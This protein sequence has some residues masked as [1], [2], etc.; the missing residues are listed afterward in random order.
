[1]DENF[2][3]NIKKRGTVG[4]GIKINS[5]SSSQ[6]KLGGYLNASIRITGQDVLF[7]SY[8]K[9]FLPGYNSGLI[10]NDIA[11]IQFTKNFSFK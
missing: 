10:R 7:L 6:A 5:L 1:M 4:G 2:Q 9:S 8:E 3:V 11:G